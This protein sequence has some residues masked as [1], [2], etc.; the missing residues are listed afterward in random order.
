MVHSPK[1]KK[2]TILVT[3]STSR[4][5]KFLKNGLKNYSVIFTKK[6]DFNILNYKKMYNFIKNKKVDYLI[7][8]AGLSRPMSI[9]DK[10]IILSIDLNIVGTANIVKLCKMKNIKLIYFSTSYVY[11]GT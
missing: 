11:P 5:C 8:I 3:G 7:H 10:N 2:K 4:F 9:H 6:K 1:L